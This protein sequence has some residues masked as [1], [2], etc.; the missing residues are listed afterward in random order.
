MASISASTW[1]ALASLIVSASV[2][3]YQWRSWGRANLTAEW[4]TRDT[5]M[6]TNHGPG[7]AKRV[8]VILDETADESR[9][10]IPYL[11][12][13]QTYRILYDRKLGEKF[14]DPQI[15]WRDN[16]IAEQ[17]AT[18][19]TGD[20]PRR[21]PTPSGKPGLESQLR[22]LARE[23]ARAEIEEQVRRGVRRRR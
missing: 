8:K 9:S 19:I 5:V 1:V 17:R 21:M 3:V 10:E 18:V 12:V 16:H 13:Y 11:G 23:E 20:P 14:P 15:R 7:P 22:S 4:L 2:A 6:I